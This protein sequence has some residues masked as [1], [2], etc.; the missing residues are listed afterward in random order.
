MLFALLALAF[1]APA[2]AQES[3][4]ASVFKA[5]P[6]DFWQVS[7]QMDV[8]AAY[9][10]LL[11]DHPG[12]APEVG[13]AKFRSTLETA[14]DLAA[15]RAR[16]VTSYEGYAATLA[17][18]ANALG[19]KHLRS[20]PFFVLARPDWAG[21]IMAKHGDRWLVADQQAASPADSLL[22]AELIACDGR[23]ADDWGRQI[24]GGYRAD[25]SVEAQQEQAAPW[26]L[27]NERN[28]FVPRPSTCEF[29][30]AGARRE[31]R[32]QW[33]SV[34]RDAL[35]LRLNKAAGG[36]AAGYGVRQ[37][38]AGYWIALQG[39]AD[40]RAIAVVNAVRGEAAAM[41]EAPFVILD[42]RGNGGGSSEFGRQIAY[43]LFGR[44]FVEAKL[45]ATGDPCG[46]AWR[47]S[48]ANIRELDYYLTALSN[49][50]PEF[51]KYFQALRDQATAAAKA[52]RAFTGP[53][54]CPA[55]RAT[56]AIPK[57]QLRARL[58][59]ITDGACFSSCLDVVE[60]F[61]N[62]GATQIGRTT[63]ADTRYAEVSDRPMPSG[64][65]TFSTL[66]AVSM[67]EPARQGPFEPAQVFDGDIADTAA[68]QAWA[69]AIA[70]KP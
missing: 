4:A 40:D 23:P 15:G 62:L 55:R 52:G 60:D 66:M 29:V 36:G 67:S 19:D 35:T 22:G 70:S 2:L 9:R 6:T 38:G 54:S 5:A 24:L 46:S 51:V 48:P 57:A 59:V 13:D 68:V 26:L 18:F 11:S 33:R 63:D 69:V 65:S 34:G 31:V 49:R 27:V 8:Q 12:S 21:L 17:A 3:G 7:A 43:E 44:P 47:V 56:P 64:L 25:W 10:M 53:L 16:N 58:F 45:G 1:A 30:Q 20:R 32:L 28:P 61:R 39:L 42:L 50:G 14:H 41:R 37:L